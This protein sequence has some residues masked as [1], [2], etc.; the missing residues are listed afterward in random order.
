[1]LD[2]CRIDFR[3]EV[4]FPDRVA[5]ELLAHEHLQQLFADGLDRGVGQQDFDLAAAIVHFDA[6]LDQDCSIARP[7]NGG[8]ARIGLHALEVEVYLRH[9]LDGAVRVFQDH[10]DHAPGQRHFDGRIGPPLDANVAADAPA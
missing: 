6:Q 7:R 2:L 3:G 1:D 10:L 4:T 5:A 9:W 8:E